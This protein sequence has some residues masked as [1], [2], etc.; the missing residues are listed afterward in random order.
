[1]FINKNFMYFFV[2]S[3]FDEILQKILYI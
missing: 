2:M 3:I 1:V